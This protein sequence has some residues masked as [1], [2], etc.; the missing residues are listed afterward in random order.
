M[1]IFLDDSPTKTGHSIRGIGVYTRNLKTY[2][3]AEFTNSES[4]VGWKLV[5]QPEQADLIHI[6]Y[7]D[8]FKSTLPNSLAL[9]PKLRSTFTKK[10]S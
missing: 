3:Q 10:S 7:F 5:D 1:N 6:P 4:L 2:L 8:L 9:S